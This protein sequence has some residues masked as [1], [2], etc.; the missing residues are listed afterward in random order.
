MIQTPSPS[1]GAMGAGIPYFVLEAL[2]D[3][4]CSDHEQDTVLSQFPSDDVLRPNACVRC[5]PRPE[6]AQIGFR[7]E[8]AGA[9]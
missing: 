3:T 8:Y 2:S 6:P 4:L 5:E 1:T 9:V 7:F